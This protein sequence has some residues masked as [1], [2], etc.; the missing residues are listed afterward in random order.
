[1]AVSCVYFGRVMGSQT[2][3]SLRCLTKPEG[4]IYSKYILCCVFCISGRAFGLPL[5]SIGPNEIVD[6]Q[7]IDPDYCE[8]G[9]LPFVFD[10]RDK[11]SLGSYYYT[12]ATVA[13]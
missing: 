3:E 8:E 4:L 11:I 5:P 7:L 1:M 9:V 6:R 12:A 13:L 2:L 10:M